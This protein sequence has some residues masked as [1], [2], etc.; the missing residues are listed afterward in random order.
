M[1]LDGLHTILEK[2]MEDKC[3]GSKS[4]GLERAAMRF[5]RALDRKMPPPISLMAAEAHDYDVIKCQALEFSGLHL[6][7]YMSSQLL[8][9][10]NQ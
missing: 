2:F 9:G 1:N 7:P 3:R 8:I 5:N 6:R 10:H 4:P